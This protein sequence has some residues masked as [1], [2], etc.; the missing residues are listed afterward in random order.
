MTQLTL[1]TGELERLK[2]KFP[3]K[4]PVFITKSRTSND[5]VPELRKQKFLVPAQLS[6]SEFLAT[7]RRSLM[8]RPEQAIFIFI[9]YIA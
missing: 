8:L 4:V 9:D 3:D 7:I 2:E 6:M 5:S 1:K